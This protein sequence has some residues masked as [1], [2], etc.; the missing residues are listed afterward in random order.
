MHRT[1]L[2]VA[3][4]GLCVLLALAAQILARPAEPGLLLTACESAAGIGLLI[5]GF[6]LMVVG[7]D[8]WDDVNEQPGE[9]G[10]EGP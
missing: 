9:S 3:A 8:P 4:V 7:A 5:A 6:A 1:G 10:R 2:A